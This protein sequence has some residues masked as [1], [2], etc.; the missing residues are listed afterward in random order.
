MELVALSSEL[1]RQTVDLRVNVSMA[2]R[3][4][5]A[6]RM[7]RSD[8]MHAALEFM[9]LVRIPRDVMHRVLFSTLRCRQPTSR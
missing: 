8:G 3:V 7:L 6:Q 2:S 4:D 1:T 5:H 9:Q